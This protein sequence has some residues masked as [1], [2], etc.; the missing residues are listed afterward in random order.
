MD[1]AETIQEAFGGKIVDASQNEKLLLM[2]MD[3]EW[4]DTVSIQ[5]T[6]YGADHLGSAAVPSR[7]SDLKKKGH[8]I[9]SEP[10]VENPK[11]WRYRLISSLGSPQPANGVGENASQETGSSTTSSREVWTLPSHENLTTSPNSVIPVMS[12]S[13]AIEISK[14]PSETPSMERLEHP[15][16]SELKKR[17][18]A[19]R[20]ALAEAKGLPIPEETIR[21]L[22]RAAVAYSDA[23]E[24]SGTNKAQRNELGAEYADKGESASR[25]ELLMNGS[26]F[27]VVYTEAEAIADG[28][29]EIVNALKR[30]SEHWNQSYQH[31]GI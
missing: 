14:S 15:K 25:C 23:C 20:D 5:K 11:I 9:Q 18:K 13:T 22:S 24:L 29:L 8:L 16:L 27:G 10:T 30:V 26:E 21:L 4:H 28:L 2:L 3:G 6:V 19:I 1:T 17:T 31:A 12:P 7:I